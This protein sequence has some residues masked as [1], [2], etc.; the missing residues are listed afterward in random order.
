MGRFLI[1]N[2]QGQSDAIRAAALAMEAAAFRAVEQWRY[3]PPASGPIAFPM[4]VTFAVD[5]EVTASRGRGA[6]PPRM[7]TGTLQAPGA[8]RVGGNVSAPTKIKDVRPVYPPIAQSARVSGVVIVEILVGADGTV[9]EAQVVRSIPLLDAAAI[10]AVK[11]WQYRPTLLNGVAV[12]AIMTVTVSFSLQ[13]PAPVVAPV[14]AAREVEPEPRTPRGKAPEVILE[15]KPRYSAEALRAGIEGSVEIEAVI[16]TDGTVT[17]ARVIKGHPMFH[18]SA[19]T[20]V[21][22]WRFKPIPEPY[23]ATIELTFTTRK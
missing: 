16:G 7:I 2:D 17:S 4:V 12:P 1:N 15:V 6:A 10:E 11:Q 3:E 23:T 21:S 22:Q 8:V 9:Q 19:T 5:G 14:E 20:A 13:G 18:E